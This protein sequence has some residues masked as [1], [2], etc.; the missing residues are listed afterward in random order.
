MVDE[1]LHGLF[2]GG[3][4][5]RGN[6]VVVDLDNTERHFV[7]AL[8]DDSKRLSH[9]LHSAEVSKRARG[10]AGRPSAR[11]EKQGLRKRE[12]GK[13]ERLTG[14][15]NLHSFR[16]GHQT[17]PHRTCRTAGP[18]CQHAGQKLRIVSY[19]AETSRYREEEGNEPQIPRDTGSSQHDAR[20]GVVEGLGGRDVSDT[21]GSDDPDSVRGND[22]LDL[23][24]PAP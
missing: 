15:S 1:R 20:E 16:R 12:R 21:D 18:S 11:E 17:R 10:P 14:R 24:E 19:T 9:L 13:N 6:L 5:G 23:V 22:F 7:Q 8:V 2:H 3:S 4:R